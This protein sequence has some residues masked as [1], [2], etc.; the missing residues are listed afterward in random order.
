MKK[1]K[2]YG[3]GRWIDNSEETYNPKEADIIILPGGADINPALYGHK[4]SR[5]TR[6][7]SDKTDELHNRLINYAIESNKMLFGICRGLV[8]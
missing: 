1:L 3:D 5:M 6:Y 2:Y 8:M 4:A 7:W